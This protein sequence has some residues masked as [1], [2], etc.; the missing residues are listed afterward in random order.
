MK[1]FFCI[2]LFFLLLSLLSLCTQA[3]EYHYHSA[4]SGVSA[5]QRNWDLLMENLP[6]TIQEELQGISFSNLQSTADSLAQK[7]DI[8]YWGSL[9]LKYIRNSITDMPSKIAP[10][11]S[12]MLLTAAMQILLPAIAGTGLQKTVYTYSGLLMTLLLYRQ[13]YDILRITQTSL[14]RLCKIMNL[15]TPVM[16]TVYLSAGSL[17]QRAVSTQATALFVTLSGNFNGYLLTPLTNLLFTLSAVASVCDEVKLTPLIG[18]LRKLILRMIQIFTMFFS[19]MLGSQTILAKSADTLGMKTAKFFLG[20]FIPVAGGTLAETL[21]TLR[22][23]MALVKSAAGIGG[24]LVIILLVLPDIL[25]L[26]VYKFTL[27]LAATGGELLK[28]DKFPTLPHEIHGI[29]E[30][31]TAIVLFTALL[32]VL[33]LILFTKA[34]VS[35]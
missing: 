4:D 3:E 15:M 9:I 23:G 33:L 25:Q 11:F 28:L 13:T 8:R 6:A 19:F 26:T 2:L 32:F 27:Y 5:V 20:S 16:E 10:I 29:I 30:L 31:L 14:D 18:S 12:I 21:A 34:Q 24:I 1:K 35:I 22:E 17:T 7:T